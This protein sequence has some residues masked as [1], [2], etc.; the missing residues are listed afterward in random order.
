M[1]I[2]I[3]DKNLKRVAFL[4]NDKPGTLHFY[5]DTWHRYL[6]EATSTFDFTVPKPMEAHP[7]LAFL[8]EKN[9][10]SFRYDGK[11]Y[12]FNIMKTVETE[13]KITCYCENLN[14]ELLNEDA[15]EYKASGA[16]PFVDYFNDPFL[17]GGAAYS[18][19]VIGINEISDYKRTLSWE[20]TE[21]KLARL[22]SIV[23]Q[24]DAE[25]EFETNLNRDGTLDK[26]VLNVYKAYNER[27]QGVGKRR[28]DVTLYYGKEI[29]GVHRTVDKTGLYTAIRPI[30]KDGLT[31]ASIP[32]RVV[33]D[34]NGKP[35]YTKAAGTSDIC[36]PQSA[37]EY[38]PQLS[39]K[40]DSWIV[41][42]WSYDTDNTETLYSKGLAK[43]K[44][45]CLPAITYEAE[46]TLNLGIGD[47]VIIHDAKF[48]PT[49]LLEARVSE[50]EVS[51]SD[52]TQNKNIFANFRALENQLSSDITSRLETIVENALPYTM[53]V[54]SS[55]GL[56]FKNGTGSTTLTPRILK[57]QKDVT[58]QVATA[59]YKD[60]VAT[61]SSGKLTI[62]AA[63]ITDKAVY[64]VNAVSDA[65]TVLCSA[66]VT[67]VDISDGVD[68]GIGPQGP[69]GPQGPKGDDGER[70]L[71]GLQGDKGDQGIQGPKGTN[72]VSSYTH[73]AYANSSDGT[74]GFSISDSLNKAYIGMYVDTVA[75]DSTTPSKYRWSLIKGA[76]GA[77]GIQGPAGSDGQ[78]PYLHVAYAN[79]ETGTSGFSVSDSVGK[80]YIG[81]YTDFVAADSTTPSKYSWTKIKGDKGDAGDRGPQGIQG[82]QGSKGDQGVQGPK[83]DD[84]ISTYFH[85]AYANNATGTLDFSISDSTNKLYIGTYVDSVATDSTIPSKYSWQLVKGSQG[86]KGEQGIPGTNG[87]DGRTSYLHIAYATNATGTAGFSTTDSVGKTYI[88]QYTDFTATDSTSPSAYNWSLI[89]GDTGPTGPKGDK[90]DTGATGGTGATGNGVAS[91][92]AQYYLSTSKTTQT[93]G[94][95]AA[96]MPAW[97]EGKYLWIRNKITYTSGGTVY[98][99]PYCDTGWEAAVV[100][101]GKLTQTKT[102]LLSTMSQNYATKGELQTVDG[103]FS[104]YS[105]TVQMNSAINQKANEINIGVS[106]AQTT[107][108]N[109]L[110]N[111]NKA[112]S[113]ID[114]LEV[115]GRNLLRNTVSYSSWG[116]GNCKKTVGQTDPYGGNKA[117]LVDGNTD[118]NS[119]MLTPGTVLKQTGYHSL[120]VWL[121]G[122]KAGAVYVG[123]NLNTGTD[124]SRTLCNVTTEW[125]RFTIIS[126]ETAIRTS[127]QF[128]LGG[129]SSWSDLTLGVYMAFPMLCIG[130]KPT[131][132]TPAPEDV[133]A[134]IAKVDGKFVNY[135]TTTQMNAA[136]NAKADEISLSVSQNYATKTTVQQVDGKFASYST[137]TQMNSAIQ[138]KA[139]EINQSVSSTYTTKNDTN[140]INTRLQS[141]ESKLTPTALTTT[142][143]TALSGSNT[144]ATTK[145]VMDKDG[146]LIKNGGLK[147]QNNAGVTV[148]SA[149]SA[150]NLTFKGN[151]E[152][153]GAQTMR[154][155]NTSGNPVGSIFFGAVPSG[156]EWAP[157][158]LSVKGEGLL[159]LAVS[160]AVGAKGFGQFIAGGDVVGMF[161]KENGRSSFLIGDAGNNIQ[162]DSGRYPK[163][164]AIGC[165]KV[166]DFAMAPGFS[167]ISGY[168]NNIVFN[169]MGGFCYL[170][171]TISG[172]LPAGAW[173]HILTIPNGYSPAQKIGAPGIIGARGANQINIYADGKVYAW[174]QNAHPDLSG[175]ATYYL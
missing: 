26:I 144:I 135:S 49:L 35:L 63:D 53:E 30:G 107:A 89:K 81:Q 80:L 112:Q 43:L 33:N 157:G 59:W 113:D 136:I 85:I 97:S 93:G 114:G 16:K 131:D 64:K 69:P 77:Q 72:G 130:N 147:I 41:L 39:S 159:N 156:Y 90:G 129:W 168:A 8:T 161:G 170:T 116:A 103:K 56:I 105:T 62:T 164:S 10:V 98:T 127:Y 167:K 44:S 110:T 51:F 50:Q 15:S 158:I 165:T 74:I 132:W 29:K 174:V 13:S 83:G 175:F 71:Q 22:L 134:S 143:S 151:L 14:L 37:V 172:N 149:D 1:L 67:V 3:H 88:G 87:A 106:Q 126:N 32:A 141:A 120:S 111:A 86:V 162:Y 76:D 101:D 102:E 166:V 68:G 9:Y 91:I 109:A 100:V 4:D 25:C 142:I 73:I 140:A 171:F 11:D 7:D 148:L 82:L 52:P 84:G 48:T 145:F 42:Y 118:V 125:K 34:A 57:G 36:A 47:T 17:V 58:T 163:I 99:Q 138:L 94:S 55:D 128:V 61:G 70:G 45:V 152:M 54:L 60:G 139:N 96:L 28:S 122:T 160:D 124:Q 154:I 108:N 46:G 66:E 169:A 24:F 38:P 2:S 133:D 117:V 137:T 21:S 173:T 23:K 115:G 119:Y 121:K 155:N 95:W 75:T 19:L 27:N 40:K 65:G 12:L 18:D 5:N 150:G 104:N 79:D 92:E 31:I 20:D 78:T 6:V 146:L 123:F 153:Q